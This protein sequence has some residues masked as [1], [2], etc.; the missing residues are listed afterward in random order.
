[1]TKTRPV[2]F[3]KLLI[4]VATVLWGLSF[5]VTKGAVD[6]VPPAWLMGMRFTGTALIL[7]V[8]FR[9]KLA[10][11]LDKSHLIAGIIL[12]IASFLGFWLQT[13]GIT[14][15]TPG[16]NAFLTATYCV[17]VPFV[18]WMVAHRKPTA[19]NLVAA[20]LC[21][22][23]V[24][25]VAIKDGNLTMQWGDAMTLL[26]AVF[27]AVHIVLVAVFANRHEIM[28]I[29][30]VQIAASGVLGII[31]GLAFE[32]LPQA[33]AFTMG[34]FLEL[35][36]LIVFASCLAMVFQNIGQAYVPP[37]QAALLLSLESVF[38][39]LFSVL[40]YGE[41]VTLQLLAGFALIFGA[42]V[43]SEVFPLPKKSAQEGASDSAT[44]P[45]A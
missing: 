29:T 44:D 14:D 32:P 7:I 18:Y 24:G 1:M 39:V 6:A 16:K 41:E 28:T 17:M 36:Y 37:A 30:I 2:W 31:F 42:I 43:I 8:A 33:S 22:A 10:R 27:F 40:L 45:N 34:F 23:G 38:G 9:K 26:S 20:V 5:V 12:G 25:L 3:Y 35:G 11:N 19:Y 13:V 15:T 21:I 4:V